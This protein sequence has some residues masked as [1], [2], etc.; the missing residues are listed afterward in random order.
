MSGGERMFIKTEEGVL[1]NL[2]EVQRIRT[3]NSPK[4][5]F[6]I[7][8]DTQ[9]TTSKPSWVFKTAKERDDAFGTLLNE[10]NSNKL[11]INPMLFF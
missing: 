10:L 9:I 4:G 7:L 2:N 5:E 3:F 6:T 1:Y 8:F 11:L